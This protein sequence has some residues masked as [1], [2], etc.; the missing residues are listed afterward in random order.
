MEHGKSFNL[1]HD[2]HKLF[3]TDSS[4]KIDIDFGDYSTFFVIEDRM[5]NHHYYATKGRSRS[6]L[7]FFNRLGGYDPYNYLPNHTIMVALLLKLGIIYIN[8]FGIYLLFYWLFIDLSGI[9]VFVTSIGVILWGG[10][11]LYEKYLDL[12]VKKRKEDEY[13]EKHHKK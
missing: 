5:G 9:K 1:N 6:F 10:M 7:S 8:L 4:R 2:K 13:Q 11:K 3:K 12:K